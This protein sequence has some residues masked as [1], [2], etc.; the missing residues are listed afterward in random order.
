MTAHGKYRVIEAQTLESLKT[1]RLLI[2][3]ALENRNLPP[4]MRA[5]LEKELQ[6]ALRK[7]IAAKPVLPDIIDEDDDE[8]EETGGDDGSSTDSGGQQ[9]SAGGG[10]GG[11][12]YS[13][14][15]YAEGAVNEHDGLSGV[16]MISLLFFLTEQAVAQPIEVPPPVVEATEVLVT[17]NYV[18][19]FPLAAATLLFNREA[20]AA[21]VHEPYT[22]AQEGTTNAPSELLP[23]LEKHAAK[24]GAHVM[25][26]KVHADAVSLFQ[27]KGYEPQGRIVVRQGTPIQRMRRSLAYTNTFIP[28][29][30]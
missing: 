2:E 5:E 24:M 3:R 7:E 16:E 13:D 18:E 6:L 26:L 11:M 23:T 15:V 28:T 10:G 9:G 17:E 27:K 12:S 29:D 21:H 19:A 20:K 8:E 1:H 25:H 14:T 22:L 30:S 4:A